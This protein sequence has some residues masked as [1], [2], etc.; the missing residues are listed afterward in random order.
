[1]QF[2]VSNSRTGSRLCHV[3]FGAAVALGL[4]LPAS[5]QTPTQASAPAAPTL[6]SAAQLQTWRAALALNP[7]PAHIGCFSAKYPSAAW[8]DVPCVTPPNCPYRPA[9]AGTS[10]AGPKIVGN[11]NDYVAGTNNLITSATG[12][13]AKVAG[14]LNEGDGGTANRY[15]LQLNTNFFYGTAAC[16]TAANP[17]NCQGWEQF[18]YSNSA[19]AF[20]QYWLIN[21]ATT[22]P[23]GWN[24]GGKDCW[25][26]APGGAAYG[27]EPITNLSGEQVT[28]STNGTTDTIQISGPGGTASASNTGT[29]LGLADF[30]NNAEFNIVG[31]CCGS[32]A[33]FNS[34][35][36]LKVSTQ[37][38]SGTTAAPACGIAGTTGETNNT[39]LVAP[40]TTIKGSKPGISFSESNPPGS[41]WVY[42]GTPCN[43]T[44]CTGW[45]ELDNNN[46]SVRIAATSTNQ[47]YQL[48]NNG[49]VY[50]YDGTPCSGS[51]CPGWKRLFNDP[52]T[53]E[54]VAGGNHLYQYENDGK[55]WEYISATE[56]NLLDDNTTITTMVAAS[57]G[58]YELHNNGAIWQFTGTGC[59]NTNGND[60]PGWQQIDDNADSVALT[61]GLDNLYEMHKDGTIWKYTNTPCT[62][63]SCP[64]WKQ[65]GNNGNAL[66]MEA[67]GNNLYELDTTGAIW[68]YTGT[69]CSKTACT[70]WQ[71]LDN[72]PAAMEITADNESNLYELHTDGTV[73]KYTGTPCSGNS[74]GGWQMID[75][76]PWIGRIAASSGMLYE[77]HVVQVPTA[78]ANICYECR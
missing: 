3:L 42:T 24:T 52:N 2:S 17:A 14:V 75:D 21:Y 1:M 32:T 12:S 45:Q 28:G 78:R 72:N 10:A 60:C 40:C 11:G 4:S 30:W 18:V 55:L 48:W 22:C 39:N 77:L 65:L 15:S 25:K 54:I 66:A 33:N 73:W 35:V 50:K 29:V 62:G 26:N 38:N 16:N 53:W 46:E 49:A 23:S 47:L 69:A 6:L 8:T 59:T 57:G 51:S 34:G 20:I 56:W 37:V 68:K 58:L 61:T 70:G 41:I 63:A 43:G 64:G 5:A 31:D 9:H 67:G 71:Q 27:P 19:G 74:C 7:P 36:T 13:F 76:N 44:T